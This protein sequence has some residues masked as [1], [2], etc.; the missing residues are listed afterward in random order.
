MLLRGK[1]EK[2]QHEEVLYPDTSSLH[3]RKTEIRRNDVVFTDL[4]SFLLVE[5]EMISCAVDELV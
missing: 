3:S 2:T 1:L 5:M 4:G